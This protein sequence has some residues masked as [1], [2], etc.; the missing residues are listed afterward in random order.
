MS[1]YYEVLIYV[2]FFTCIVLY[3]TGSYWKGKY[4]GANENNEDMAEEIRWLHL[5]NSPEKYEIFYKDM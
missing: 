5:M 2:L 1:Q 4:E 3:G